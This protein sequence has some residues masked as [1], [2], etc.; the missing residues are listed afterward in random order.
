MHGSTHHIA[1]VGG[2]PA[3]F[4]DVME[5]YL[6]RATHSKGSAHSRRGAERPSPSSSSDPATSTRG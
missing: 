6:Q 2:V 4:D 1:H 3:P 5:R